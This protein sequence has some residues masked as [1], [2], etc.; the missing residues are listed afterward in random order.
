MRYHYVDKLG[1][2][3]GLLDRLGTRYYNLDGFNNEIIDYL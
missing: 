3:L 1:S 2:G